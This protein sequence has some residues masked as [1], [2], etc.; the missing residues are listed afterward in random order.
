MKWPLVLIAGLIWTFMVGA[1]FAQQANLAPNNIEFW[2]NSEHWTT[3]FGP[4]FRD[5]IQGV[6]YFLPCTAQFALCF[7]SGAA[8]DTCTENST[9]RFAKCICTVN[10]SI[11]YVLISAILNYNVYQSTVAAC[12]IDGSGCQKPDSAPV[13]QFLANG[14]L[15]PG[16]KV[17]STYDVTSYQD[18]ANAFKEGTSAVTL[19]DGAYAACMT[20]GCQFQSDGTALC[21]CPIFHGKFQLV[22]PGAQCNLGDSLVPSAGYIPA[23]DSGLLP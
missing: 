2:E 21:K 7:H 13:C 10:K 16:A 20:A 22:G 11:N 4:T 14:K 1:A 18:V 8:P 6:S 23:L 9:G 12:G 19:C 3:N 17:I 5:T 15:L